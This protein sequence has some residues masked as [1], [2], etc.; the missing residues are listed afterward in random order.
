MIITESMDGSNRLS[1]WY[2]PQQ[3][4]D[5]FFLLPAS[6][7]N[8]GALDKIRHKLL[9]PWATFRI[10]KRTGVKTKV[11]ELDRLPEDAPV[12]DKSRKDETSTRAGLPPYSVVSAV[13]SGKS[14]NGRSFHR[15]DVVA[16]LLLAFGAVKRAFP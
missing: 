12:K 5:H 2:F 13:N 9:I 14:N 1:C 4:R 16:V 11:L 8:H 10:H 3:D 15:S 6:E 7:C